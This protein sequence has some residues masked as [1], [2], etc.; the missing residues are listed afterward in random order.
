MDSEDSTLPPVD[1]DPKEFPNSEDWEQHQHMFYTL[2]ESILKAFRVMDK[3]LWLHPTIDCFCSGTTAVTLIKQVQ[4]RVLLV[5][6]FCCF[7][8]F[9]LASEYIIFETGQGFGYW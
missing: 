2:K 9:G 1:I 8:A 6:L 4:R 3:E 7:L 5:S